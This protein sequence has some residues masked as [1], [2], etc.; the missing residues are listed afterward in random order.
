MMLVTRPPVADTVPPVI[1]AAPAITLAAGGAAGASQVVVRAAWAATDAGTGIDRHVLEVSRDGGPYVARGGS[2]AGPAAT[3]TLGSGHRYRVRVRA[4]D[5]AGNPGGWSASRTFGVTARQES[6]TALRWAG[7]WRRRVD[8]RFWGRTL[9]SSGT[10]GATATTTFTG[11]GIAWVAEMGPGRGSARVY[12][13]GKAVATV[14]LSRP[15][16]APRRIAWARHWA[17]TGT[18]TVRIRVLGTP[19]G[20]PR[21]DVDGFEI[22]R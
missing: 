11:R 12:V 4:V 22:L 17:A 16:F 3:L 9:R 15:A 5:R 1:T 13:D 8:D 10:A 7:S 19:T 21:V 18:H 2:L 6:S 14:S 20:N